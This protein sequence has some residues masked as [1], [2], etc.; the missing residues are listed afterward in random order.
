MSKFNGVKY[1]DKGLL[2][3]IFDKIYNIA[4]RG[5]IQDEYAIPY[6]FEAVGEIQEIT[7]KIYDTEHKIAFD[8]IGKDS[9][10][11]DYPALR[12]LDNLYDRLAKTTNYKMFLYGVF[13]N[14]HTTEEN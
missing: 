5:E 11:D 4:F 1:V 2:K 7:D 8:V 14:L 12:D 9:D 3:K 6:K 13:L 10:I